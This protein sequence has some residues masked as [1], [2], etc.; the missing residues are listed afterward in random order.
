MAV[1]KE[2]DGTDVF[3]RNRIIYFNGTFT[4][5]K[6]QETVKKLLEFEV[7][8]PAKDIII[9]ID[10]NG[11]FVDSF[12]AIHD[13][14]QMLTSEVAT[15]CL[16]KAMSCGMLLLI[17]GKKGKRF[18][19]KNSRVLV[20]ELAAGTIGK[21]SDMDIDIKEAQRMQDI[22]DKMVLDYT[23][24]PKEDIREFMS[25]D[26]YCPAERAKELGIVDYV[27]DSYSEIFKKLNT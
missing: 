9:F 25:K 19:T 2:N 27:V 5:N 3:Q 10:T 11:G 18:I 20:H 12:F 13:T 4:E 7:D 15:V 17:T 21:L 24:I 6:V 26:T 1:K 14:I 23:D 16:G 8:D 22:I